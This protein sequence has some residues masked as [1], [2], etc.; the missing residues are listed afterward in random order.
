[1]KPGDIGVL[2]CCAVLIVYVAVFGGGLP[3]IPYYAI[4]AVAVGVAYLA[5]RVYQRRSG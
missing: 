1:M 2:A 5:W 3:W 4:G